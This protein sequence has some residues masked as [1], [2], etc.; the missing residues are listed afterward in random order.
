[1][2]YHSED[3]EIALHYQAQHDLE[4]LL[5]QL[6]PGETRVRISEYA[7]LHRKSV[8]VY[9]K[10]HPT[11]PFPFEIS[12]DNVSDYFALGQFTLI[13]SE[14]SLMNWRTHTTH[15][16]PVCGQ[17]A[18]LRMTIREKKPVRD[19]ESRL[20]YVCT[21][22]TTFAVDAQGQAVDVQ[23]LSQQSKERR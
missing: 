7:R 18:H 20:Q 6:K 1:M 21:C 16:C 9:Q 23:G 13:E 10:Y 2:T 5:S 4:Q 15:Q 8:G 22:G 19:S 17:S 3:H 14:K 11:K 12:I